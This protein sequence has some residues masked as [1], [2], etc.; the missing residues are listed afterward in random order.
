MNNTI[1]PDIFARYT[2]A[3]YNKFQKW[4]NT[5]HG[6]N[7]YSMFR[8]FS[9]AYKDA[10][11]DHCGANLIGNRVRWEVSVGEYT[12]YKVSND[13]LPMMARQLVL[14]DASFDGFF[15]FHDH[16]A[17]DIEHDPIA[18]LDDPA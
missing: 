3:K 16:R 6:Q 17:D 18:D 15:N 4:L 8:Q 12:G 13:F 5:K 7:I 2:Q 10:G 11:H 1:M 14:D 9:N